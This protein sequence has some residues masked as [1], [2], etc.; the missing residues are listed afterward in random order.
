MI[1]YAIVIA[2]L[3]A[4]LV[5][6]YRTLGGGASAVGADR[7]ASLREITDQTRRLVQSPPGPQPGLLLSQSVRESRRVVAGLQQ[8]LEMLQ[9]PDGDNAEGALDACLRLAL[10]D[11]S[12]AW[13]LAESTD[14]AENDGLRDAAEVLQQHAARAIASALQQLPVLP[15]PGHGP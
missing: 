13:R 8:R 15:E 5:I 1:V 3:V 9:P 4:L 12:W 7:V 10:E 11:L 6:A 14:W 2:G